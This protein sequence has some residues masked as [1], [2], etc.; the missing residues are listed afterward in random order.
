MKIIHLINPFAA[1]DNAENQITQKLTL[2]SIVKAKDAFSRNGSVEVFATCFEN[3]QIELPIEISQTAHLISSVADLHSFSSKKRL[4]FIADIFS[5][6]DFLEGDYFI[7]SNIDIALK[8]DF[9]NFVYDEIQKGFDALIIN[10]RRIPYKEYSPS[11]LPALYKIT[12]KTHPGFDCFVF[13][14][15]LQQQFELKRICV[16]IPFVEASIVHNLFCFASRPKLYPDEDLTFHLGME[17]FKDRDT[18]LYWHNR[19]TFFKEIKP[20]LWPKFNIKKFPFF[21][22][23]FPF[24]YWYWAKNPALFTLMNLKLDLRRI[25][26]NLK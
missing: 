17:I 18:Q 15:G 24:R 10:R 7:Y 22:K 12:G 4:P 21:D 8:P 16:G 25:G 19:I 2:A 23:G 13:K 9:Y 20:A 26:I 14:S 6:F 1:P 5:K 11:D 3:E